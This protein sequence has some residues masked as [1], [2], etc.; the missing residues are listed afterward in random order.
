MTGLGKEVALTFLSDLRLQQRWV[1]IENL[2]LLKNTVSVHFSF[3]MANQ[4]P[5]IC[6]VLLTY[7]LVIRGIL[8]ER[9]IIVSA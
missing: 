4:K 8:A 3:T 5:S 2:L 6:F 1:K 9:Y 7:L